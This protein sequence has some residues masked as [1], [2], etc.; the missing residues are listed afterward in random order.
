[1]SATSS[2]GSCCL[3]RDRPRAVP[4][5]HR[6]PVGGSVLVVEQGTVMALAV[7]AGLECLDRPP[8]GQLPRGA[9]RAEPDRSERDAPVDGTS[10]VEELGA[11]VDAQGASGALARA[12]R[13]RG[14]R[15]RDGLGLRAPRA[16]RA[17]R[18]AAGR[19]APAHVR[20]AVAHRRHR[21]PLAS[22]C[23]PTTT[24]RSACSRRHRAFAPLEVHTT[25]NVSELRSWATKRVDLLLLDLVVA[26]A[27]RRCVEACGLVAG[28]GA[29]FGN[30]MALVP[31]SPSP[32][33]V[34][35]LAQRLRQLHLQSAVHGAAA[36]ERLVD[37]ITRSRTWRM[38]CRRRRCRGRCW[39]RRCESR[40]LRRAAATVAEPHA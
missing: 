9:Q 27:L 30:V 8:R 22:C 16:G 35:E 37:A 20:G 19:A 26:D 14:G 23:S 40:R 24:S 28:G 29:T 10:A 32:D 25:A 3:H 2:C 1:M 15:S 18:P 31:A 13:A 12:A 33:Q 4:R 17:P 39:C 34:V 36:S 7:E 6:R 11:P 5:S 21:A 38:R